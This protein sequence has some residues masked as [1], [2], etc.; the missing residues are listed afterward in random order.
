MVPSGLLSESF[1]APG[2]ILLHAAVSLRELT[3]AEKGMET[4]SFELLLCDNVRSQH[5]QLGL[6]YYTNEIILNILN[7]YVILT[8]DTDKNSYCKCLK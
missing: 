4:R 8:D 3:V 5:C 7:H 2:E 1:K 6:I